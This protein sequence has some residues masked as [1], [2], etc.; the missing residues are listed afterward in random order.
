[1]SIPIFCSTIIPTI[2]R[3]TLSRAVESVL[4]QEVDGFAFEVIVVN[5]SGRELPNMAWMADPRVRIFH[6]MRRERSVARNTGAACARG[7]YFHFLD[8]DDWLMPGAMLAFHKLAQQ[9]REATW[10]YGATQL[11]DRETHPLI[12]LQHGLRGNCFTQIMAGEWIP[13]QSSI[14]PAQVFFELR[15]FLPGLSS[16]QDVDL[17]RRAALM[18]DFAETETVI[19]SVG[20]GETNSSTN[21]AKY[22]DYARWAREQ[23]LNMP[24]AFAR[25][26]GSAPDGVWVG[27][28]SRIYL[29][30]MIWSLQH[31]MLFTAISRALF[32][33]MNLLMGFPYFFSRKFWKA[34]AK[35]YASTTFAKGFEDEKSKS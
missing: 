9:T 32:G 4:A 17:C 6:T 14:I 29:T 3:Q 20:M 22:L 11:V 34:I 16:T 12:Q 23:I 21:R 24:G 1:M 18:G 10:L 33:F 25:M 5:D 31:R 30:S 27:R 26:R 28:I 8:D 15:G 35:P 19:S 13:L 2:G 7:A